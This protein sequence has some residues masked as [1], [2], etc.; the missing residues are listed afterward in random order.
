MGS[1]ALCLNAQGGR[2]REAPVRSVSEEHRDLALQRL[3]HHME[4]KYIEV[5]KTTGDDFLKLADGTSEEVAQFLSKGKTSLYP[6]VS[7]DN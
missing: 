4:T 2:N 6:Y 7:A 1:T 3:R 5:Y